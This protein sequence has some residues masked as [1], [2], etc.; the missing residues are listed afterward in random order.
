MP[1]LVS[2]S[3]SENT[4]Q[5]IRFLTEF[6]LNVW[7]ILLNHLFRLGKHNQ[8]KLEISFSERPSHA[9]PENCHIFLPYSALETKLL[10][11]KITFE[12]KRDLITKWECLNLN[13]ETHL[14]RLTN[15]DVVSKAAHAHWA[16]GREI[17]VLFVNL[18][19]MPHTRQTLRYNA[20]EL[21]TWI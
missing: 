8:R 21:M 17:I 20:L 10:K 16:T 9:K 12:T 14:Y 4:D 11:C 15:A 18:N 1:G 19:Y 6:P 13:A 7:G 2:N 5:A 3:I